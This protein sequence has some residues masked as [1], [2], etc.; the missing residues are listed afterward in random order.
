[1]RNPTFWITYLLLVVAQL[2][3]SHFFRLSPYFTLCIL[4]VMVLCIPIRVGTIGAMLIAFATGITLDLISEG[5]LGLNTLALVPVGFMRN[6]VIRL[7][8]GTELFARKE[9]FSAR[10]N[11]LGKVALAALIAEAVFF[12]LYIWVDSA[13][14]RPF[15]FNL[16]RF[17]GSL[18]GSMLLS[19]L[20]IE[21]LAP[22]S[23]R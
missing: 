22:D 3:L 14:T 12:I 20:A 23:R 17:I 9:D 1:M 15:G 7:I 13:G 5:V 18:S 4:P 8:F 19:L 2:V 21:L 10:R 11:G 16:L 6:W